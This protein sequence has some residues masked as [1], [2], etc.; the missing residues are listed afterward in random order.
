[1][2]NAVRYLPAFPADLLPS[3]MEMPAS[4]PVPASCFMGIDLR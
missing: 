3:S 2:L 4:F 1:M